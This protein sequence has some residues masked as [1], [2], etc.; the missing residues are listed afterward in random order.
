MK[1]TLR[2]FEV[3]LFVLGTIVLFFV[4]GSLIKKSEILH[5]NPSY[6]YL[7][8]GI[9]VGSL[10][11]LK[12][13]YESLKKGSF[14][15]DY[16]AILAIITGL[17]TQN[18]LVASVIVLMMSTGNSLEEY[19]TKKA[20]DSLR[21]L[22]NRIPND[23]LVETSTGT[24]ETIPTDEVELG[25]LVVVRKGEVIPLDG[26]LESIRSDFDESSLTGEALPVS[27]SKGELVK[28]GTINLGE[29]VLIR[30]TVIEK[31]STFKKIVKLVNEAQSKKAPFIQL[32]DKISGWF[33]VL[34]LLIA[35]FGYFYL[36]GIG[37]F[38][39]V[40][41]IATPCPLLLAVPIA[42]LGGV[43]SAAKHRIVF[44]K[45]SAL[46]V[47]SRVNAVIFDKTG[48]LTLGAPVLKKIQLI[49]KSIDEGKLL[50][51]A[52][53]LERNSFH[54]YAKAILNFVD[55]KNIKP[56]QMESIEE[57]AGV[58]L[59][60]VF[61]GHSY[62]IER[63]SS[64]N[65]SS[66]TMLCDGKPLCEFIFEDE[67]KE[68]SFA[69]LNKLLK[70]KIKLAIFTGDTK[71]RTTEMLK[72]ISNE[73]E[74]TSDCSPTDKLDGVKNFRSKGFTTAMIGDG[75]NDAPAL[76][77][78]DVGIVFSHQEQTAATEASDVVLLNGN[79][80]SVLKTFSISRR[81]MF[82]A[83]QSMYIGV[84]LSVLG[85]I[86]ASLGYVPPLYGA[87]IQEVIDVAVIINALRAA[88]S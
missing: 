5:A 83:K 64:K 20:S 7:W 51:I 16:I 2:I 23:V 43:S 81:T 77:I 87:V 71:Q 15:L 34:T 49:S 30:T 29:L 45:L 56:V 42:L 67:V 39:S 76:A 4:F 28:S 58:G 41:V 88:R 68:S 84:G 13:T 79:L 32:A 24:R 9:L 14:A 52:S 47:M 60:G 37:G 17:Y 59:S 48:T 78:S 82:I 66:A 75:I 70:S 57:Q 85:M 40:L 80:E 11:L 54:P 72:N 22:E 12:E 46:E 65:Y 31:D 35:G 27:K 26:V 86:F 74:I 44:R 63:G 73:V 19:A 55:S 10:K 53:A 18:Y 36:G 6:I 50:S 3:P 69:V 8:V 33:T 38:L 62:K 25:S 61:D 21:E 1:K